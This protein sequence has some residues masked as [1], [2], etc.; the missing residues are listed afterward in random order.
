LKSSPYVGEDVNI[1]GYALEL[2]T[3]LLREVV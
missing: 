1:L 3:G 2:E